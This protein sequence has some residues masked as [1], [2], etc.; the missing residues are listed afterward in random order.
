MNIF[1]GILGSAH[2]KQEDLSIQYFTRDRAHLIASWRD[3]YRPL[4]WFLRSCGALSEE[5]DTKRYMFVLSAC[6]KH[7]DSNRLLSL[8]RM[9]KATVGF[10]TKKTQEEIRMIKETVDSATKKVEGLEAQM[11][12]LA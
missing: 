7:S 6:D 1:V 11:G 9:I 4:R 12:T 10:A 2:D 8:R 3:Q 5:V